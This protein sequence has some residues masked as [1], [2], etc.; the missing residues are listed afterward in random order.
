MPFFTEYIT[1][2]ETLTDIENEGEGAVIVRLTAEGNGVGGDGEI[3]G[4]LGILECEGDL[5]FKPWADIEFPIWQI[6]S[7]NAIGGDSELPILESTGQLTRKQTGT[8][9]LPLLQCSGVG[10]E[11]NDGEF[12]VYLLVT[13]EGNANRKYILCE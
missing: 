13:G 8:V 12:F 5:E 4:E 2:I 10:R 7:Q 9:S 11:G 1:N 6:I 3:Y